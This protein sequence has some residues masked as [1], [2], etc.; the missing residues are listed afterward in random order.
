M[1]ILKLINRLRFYAILKSVLIFSLV[2]ISL[3]GNKLPDNA[4]EFQEK[5]LDTLVTG[6]ALLIYQAPFPRYSIFYLGRD[7]KYV[8]NS[9]RSKEV[10][11]FGEENYYSIAVGGDLKKGKTEALVHDVCQPS[12]EQYVD[13]LRAEYSSESK[14]WDFHYKENNFYSSIIINDTLYLLFK[15]NDQE[16]VSWFRHNRKNFVLQLSRKHERTN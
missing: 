2:W 11:E 6:H 4:D 1:L 8:K 15:T 10:N 7:Y 3:C 16:V 12:S 9:Y 5:D 14:F 13:I